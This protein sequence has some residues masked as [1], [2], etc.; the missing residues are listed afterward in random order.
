MLL[1]IWFVK[2][3]K[4]N[5]AASR[6]RPLH[7]YWQL[8]AAL[9]VVF[10]PSSILFWGITALMYVLSGVKPHKRRSVMEQGLVVGFSTLA[11]ATLWDR[12]W[13]GRQVFFDKNIDLSR[14]NSW[15]H[16][17]I[18]INS[19]GS[20]YPGIFS[21]TTCWKVDR[22]FTECIHGIGTSRR[23][24]QPYWHPCYLSCLWV[25]GSHLGKSEWWC[26]MW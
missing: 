13:Y 9:S 3:D 22:R 5:I 24:F 11:F 2:E 17:V 21:H 7:W 10:R 6:L 4:A 20:L 8:M 14:L 26:C 18:T 25:F 16:Y 23:G 15:K 19:G 1:S 12:I